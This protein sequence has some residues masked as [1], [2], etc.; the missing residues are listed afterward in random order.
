[1]N[2]NEIAKL[3][4]VSRATVSRYLNDGYVSEEKRKIIQEVIEKTGYQPSAQAQN[5]RKQM[6]GLIGVIIPRIQSEAV[7]RMVAGISSILSEAGYQ[8]LLANTQNDEKKELSYLKTFSKNYVDGIIFIGT[9]FTKAHFNL[10]KQLEVPIVILGQQVEGYS[11][12]YQ[13]DYHAAKEAARLLSNSG[14]QIGYIGV[15]TRDK[16]AGAQRKRGFLDELREQGIQAV[17]KYMTEADFGVEAG[18]EAAKRLMESS[19]EIDSFFCATDSIAIGA[20]KRLREI[21]KIIPEEV[22]LIGF[23]DNAIG[24]IVEPSITT[25][26][27]YYQTSG[28]EAARLLLEIISSGEDIKKEIKMGFQ[29]KAQGSTRKS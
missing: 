22:Q 11:C 5:L 3:A 15:T 14:K 2:I 17:E 8:L 28:K 21:G 29:L 4:G 23:G 7:N 1:M 26:H 27:F 19:P 24:R 18:Y 13:D 20:L 6:T 9:I 16:A 10:I 25:I 12:V